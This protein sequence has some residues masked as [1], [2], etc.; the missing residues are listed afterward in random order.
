MGFVSVNGKGGIAGQ[1][2]LTVGTATVQI[3]TNDISCS[4]IEIQAD[5]DNAGRIHY[6]DSTLDADEGCFVDATNSDKVISINSTRNLYVRATE[7][8]QVLYWTA[9]ARE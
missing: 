5:P 4:A 8:G 7:A 3:D 9:L 2:K 1:G 6:G